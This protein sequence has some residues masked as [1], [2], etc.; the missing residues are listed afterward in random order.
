MYAFLKSA[1]EVGGDYYDFFELSEDRL[2]FVIADVSGKGISAAFIMAE[3][4]GI[5]ESLSKLIPSP[6]EVLIKANEILKE[7]L[8]KKSFVTA[9]YGILDT[10]KGILN[11]ARAGH[12]PLLH[13]SGEQLYTLT[14]KGIGLGLD[15]CENFSENLKEMEIKLNNN[16]ILI[17]FTDGIPE[18]QN[19]RFE[20]F[21][22]DKLKRI[23]L[24][25]SGLNIE[26]ISDNI[27][28]EV[29]L[30]SQDNSQHDDIT[31]VL[32]KWFFNN[33]SGEN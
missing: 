28:Q 33:T 27:M 24:K 19:S 9:I 29:S 6:R 13:L 14:P 11:I 30:F 20:E 25:N 18:S 16:D 1:R 12:P 15:Y 2:G 23:I 22:Y 32:F 7:S 8:E 3:V 4:K 31:L 21:G 5:F 26:K 10:K 17:L